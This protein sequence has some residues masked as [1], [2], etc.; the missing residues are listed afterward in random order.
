MNILSV[1]GGKVGPA[2][3]N[4]RV[5]LPL[6]ALRDNAGFNVL[7]VH[8]EHLDKI[9]FVPD[10][11]VLNRPV[12]D[13]SLSSWIAEFT[14]SFRNYGAHIVIET[15]DD[16]I[17]SSADGKTTIP[18]L[19]HCDAMTVATHGLKRLYGKYTS[20][21]IYVTKNSINTQW[22]SNV[23]IK[24]KR[25]DSR[26][27]IGLIGTVSH[28]DDWDVMVDAM[29]GIMAKYD[30]RF[31]CTGLH[32][33]YMNGIAEFVGGCH[34]SGYPK[35]MRQIDIL[36]CPL[37]PNKKFNESKSAI[38]A[39]EGWAA[40]R[41]LGNGKIGGCAVIAARLTPYKGIV[42]HKHNGLLVDHNPRAWADAIEL[43]VSNKIQRLKFQVEGYKDVRKHHDISGNWKQWRTAYE[44][45]RRIAR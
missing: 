26:L 11:V 6:T 43:L 36:C 12:A 28:Y 15:D 39:I 40:A 22:F 1:I 42:Q 18:Y 24:A 23:S 17:T 13:E 38:K 2:V 19:R 21:P 31:T 8:S 34:Y 14:G 32:P 25:V 7:S 37:D 3:A 4:Y 30:V 45:I 16:Y 27:T 9:E 29:R 20:V 10:I 41:D 35:L 33:D 5:K 44:K